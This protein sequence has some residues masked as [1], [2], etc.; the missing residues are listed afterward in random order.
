MADQI[1]D[2]ITYHCKKNEFDA[3]EHA[4]ESDQLSKFPKSW[5][6]IFRAHIDEPGKYTPLLVYVGAL[7]LTS[8][9]S[10]NVDES[11][12]D[13][14]VRLFETLASKGTAG[15]LIS[16]PKLLSCLRVVAHRYTAIMRERKQPALAMRVLFNALHAFRPDRDYL[17]PMHADYLQLALVAKNPDAACDLLK[18]PVFEI[19][20]A[21]TGANATDF[22]AYYYYGGV[23]HAALR[24]W[25]RARECLRNVFAVP[26]QVPSRIMVLA[27]KLLTLINALTEERPI[28]LPSN[29][30]TRVEK[31][32]R[33]LSKPYTELVSA[34]Q[35]RND[36]AV[37]KVLNQD[38]AM[39]EAD[40]LAGL[41]DQAIVAAPRLAL[42]SLT[43][44][45]VSLT[46]K[47]I[48]DTVKV[49]A[50][51]VKQLLA[52][53]IG[54]GELDASIDKVTGTV[55]FGQGAVP[56]AA[57]IEDNIRRAI[58]VNQRIRDLDDRVVQS[59][60][61][62]MAKLRSSPHLREILTD[63]EKRRK[64]AGGLRGAVVDA[65][66]SVV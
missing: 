56:D 26:A 32:V 10:T 29:V 13:D 45:Y 23:A 51:T 27:F 16:R 1:V 54:R 62:V 65:L 46:L 53:M 33:D 24:Q 41:V 25:S 39:F 59:K 21:A 55:F 6:P 14:T 7:R 44:V 57:A 50:E 48:E 63:Y 52:S 64:E 20:P 49:P 4:V 42:L 38:R 37:S 3:V 15:T 47:Q 60:P 11:V 31:T 19:D 43:R 36:A 61:H 40:D 18:Q 9:S 12:P 28:V 17:T 22:M 2:A 58:E 30:E 34:L 8:S 66:R 35:E 5:Q